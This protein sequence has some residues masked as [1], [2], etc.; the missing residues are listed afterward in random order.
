[1]ISQQSHYILLDKTRI[2]SKSNVKGDVEQAKGNMLKWN[3]PKWDGKKNATH[4]AFS[5]HFPC[6]QML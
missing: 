3:M 2:S 6:I 4:E 1:M 5:K